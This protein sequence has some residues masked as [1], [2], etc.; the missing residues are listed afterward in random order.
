MTEVFQ[1][2]GK[3]AKIFGAILVKHSPQILSAL[4]VV[5]MTGAVIAAVKQPVKVEEELYELEKEEEKAAQQ[6][7]EEK[8]IQ[9]KVIKHP[10]WPRAKI[11]IKHYWLTVALMVSSAVCIIFANKI[12]LKRQAALLAAYQLST[13]NYNELKEKIVQLDG[14]KKLKFLSDDI[15]KDKMA[16]N[17][18]ST[19][20]VLIIG[21]GQHLIYDGHSGRYF[22]GRIEDVQAAE[23]EVKKQL[24][25]GQSVSLNDYY[26]MLKLPH[27]NDGYELG[28]KLS[29][30]GCKDFD[31]SYSS[32]VTDTG[33]PALVLNYE[34]GPIYEY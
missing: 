26:S 29:G 20:N 16:A 2:I 5:G 12:H 10:F 25:Y 17:P 28:W 24:V 33:R 8:D 31:I 3:G 14:K 27:V 13:M 18:L 30:P 32:H 11:Y 34:V 23:I 1:A 7:A 22:M 15:A 4:G 6:E 21:D 9:D 19:S